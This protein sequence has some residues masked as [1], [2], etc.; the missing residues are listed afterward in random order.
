MCDYNV[1]VMLYCYYMYVYCMCVV[2]LFYIACVLYYGCVLYIVY[3]IPPARKNGHA[4]CWE[5]KLLINQSINLM[6]SYEQR[7]TLRN[8]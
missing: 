3:Y 4:D 5:V 2:L 8:T 6:T 1:V 7:L